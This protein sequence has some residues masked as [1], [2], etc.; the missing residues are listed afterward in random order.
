MQIFFQSGDLSI[1]PCDIQDQSQEYDYE[2]D[3]HD[4]YLSI[5]TELIGHFDL[6]YG[7]SILCV[8]E[9]RQEEKG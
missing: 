4:P 1:Q 5:G 7:G 2:D 6:S 3:D 8:S 9:Q